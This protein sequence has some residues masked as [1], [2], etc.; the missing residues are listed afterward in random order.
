MGSNDDNKAQSG[1][2]D[3]VETHTETLYRTLVENSP[4]FICIADF[5]GKIK[6]I[7][8]T[9]SK[10]GKEEVIGRRIFDFT[11]P[12]YHDLTHKTIDSVFR[13]GKTGSF[14]TK[15]IGPESSLFYYET[16]YVPIVTNGKVASFMAIARDVTERKRSEKRLKES[17]EKYRVLF[18]GSTNPITIMD[19]DGVIL[20]VNGTSARNLRLRPEECVGKSVFD[21]MPDL[22]DEYH[23]NYRNV[24]DKGIEIMK[25][26]CVEL[27]SG[28]RWFWS[29]CQPVLD[30]DGNRHAVQAISYDITEIK[31]AEEERLKLESKLQQAQK[32]ESL[33][34]M[35]GGIAHD[36]NNL[37]MGILGNAD[38]ALKEL[39]P[40]APVRA[41]IRDIEEAAK[42]A[43]DLA[44]QML[45]YAGKGKFFV[46]RLKLSTLIEE[47]AHLLAVSVSNK[48]VIEYDFKKD[49]TLIEA[50]VTQVRQIIMNLVV[51]ASE[52]IGD[53]GGVISIRTGVKECDKR[54][55]DVIYLHEYLPEGTYSFL[56]VSDTGCGMDD[57]TMQKIF[58]PFFSSKFVGRGLGLAATLGVVRGHQ[59]A[60]KVHSEPGKGTTFRVLFPA[61]DDV[62]S[63][64][65]SLKNDRL[66]PDLRGKT[67]LLADD[68]ET[69]RVVSTHMLEVLGLRVVTTDDG[70]KALELFKENP[71]RFQFVVLDL[72]MPNMG[73]EECFSELRKIRKDIPVIL[74]SGYN[75]QNLIT[76]FSGKGLAGF[77]QKPYK[78]DDLRRVLLTAMQSE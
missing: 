29:I 60:I 35:A 40:E 46:K 38:L 49:A 78:I 59:G 26:D 22:D 37:L 71:N 15:A 28:P 76:Q 3:E 2:A 36:F 56:E 77:L 33:S 18:E 70:D 65:K 58:D 1:P 5:D 20:M 43:A 4:D 69:V 9:Y 61:K 62:P 51:N 48:T 45:A 50:D 12:E 64:V 24:V 8:R 63:P 75:E 73:G 52:A 10:H 23:Q 67:I 47:M 55:L 6:F 57:E 66:K 68:E 31:K 30:E 21:L 11:D 27:P 17:E 7:N 42:M 19:R 53:T 72:A 32:L 74:S 44:K 39:S 41:N 54:Y 16:R 34:L 14:E 13:T 25:E